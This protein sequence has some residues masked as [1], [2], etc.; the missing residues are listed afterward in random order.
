MKVYPHNHTVGAE[1]LQGIYG[2]SHMKYRFSQ[3]LSGINPNSP[4]AALSLMCVARRNA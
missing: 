4:E 3:W 2:R 1:V